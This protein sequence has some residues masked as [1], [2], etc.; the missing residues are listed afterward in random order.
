MPFSG[1]APARRRFSLVAVA[2]LLAILAAIAYGTSDFG[3]G[4]ASRRFAS[5]PVTAVAQVMGLGAAVLATVLIGGGRP[6][7][8]VLIWGAASGLGNGVGTLSLYRGLASGR[9]SLVATVAALL[10]VVLPAI[11]GLVL[12]HR[13]TPLAWIGLVTA[14][15]AVGL[16]SWQPA[17]SNQ[18]ASRGG[19]LYGVVA[20]AGFALLFIALERAGTYA[21]AWPLIPGQAVSILVVAPFAVMGLRSAGRPSAVAVAYMVGAGLL[22]GVANVLFLAS[23]GPGELPIVAALSAMGPAVTVLLARVFLAERWTRLQVVGLLL[24]GG[25]VILV[26][27]G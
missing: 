2:V 13:P 4:I 27:I 18:S 23:T 15:P 5:G 19:L 26:T 24:A 11:A 22:S 14:V 25:A 3:N 1:E 21:G 16:V 17:S 8:W 10:N 9:M 12:G 20:G 7:R 6:D